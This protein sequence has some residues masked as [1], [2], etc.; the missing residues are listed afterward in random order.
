MTESL[1]WFGQKT[2][3]EASNRPVDYTEWLDAY[4][5]HKLTAPMGA[6]HI[7]LWEW[8]EALERGVKPDTQIEVWP[9]GGAK[10][11][12]T[13]AGVAYV[14]WKGTR[15][16]VLLVSETQ[17]QADKQVQTIA[18]IL[19]EC[20]VDRSVSV[21]GHSKGW[22]RNVLRAANGFNVQGIGLDV[23]VRGIRMDEFRPDL[24]VLDDIDNE[25]DTPKITAKKEQSIKTSIIPAGSTDVAVLF[26]QN[27]II[28]HGI[29]AKL[30]DGRAD[31]LLRRN[32]GAKEPAVYDMEVELVPDHEKPDRKVYRIA[33]GTA[34]WAGQSI[35]QC[36]A[37]INEIGLEAFLRESQHEV[38]GA[39]GTFFKTSQIQTVLEI[40]LPRMVRLCRAWDFAA[41]ENGGDYTAGPLVGLGEDGLTYLLD[42]ARGQWSSERVER[43]V[44]GY[45][46]SD[47]ERWGAT[48]VR[49]PQ[50]PGQAGKAQVVAFRKKLQSIG[51]TCQ[52]VNVQGSKAIRAKPVQTE[53][54][55]GNMRMVQGG[56]NKEFTSELDLFREDEKH[57]YDDQVDGLSD[58]YNG[59]RR[60][61]LDLR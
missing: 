59:V 35:E 16:F 53:I 19:L 22:R 21:H 8:F 42:V 29:M 27:L 10:S 50:D 1:T 13:A 41:T 57:E 23:S 49:I 55:S 6:R 44:L 14:G 36:E 4:L 46:V 28:E 38:K 58:A 61:N 48:I 60:P 32:L 47:Q 30:A 37:L 24:I 25:K 54:N 5:A 51:V 18:D 3:D 43:E 7:G 2:S 33:S 56:W 34:S 26:I 45:A 52:I 31:W 39:S 12:T 17:D 11:Y 9:R 40:D 15:K 20:G